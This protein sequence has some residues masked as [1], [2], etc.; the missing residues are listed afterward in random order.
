MNAKLL[1][2]FIFLFFFSAV[3]AQ[4]FPIVEKEEINK[5]IEFANSTSIKRLIVGNI[6]GS[7][8]VVGSD[9]K[10]ILLTGTRINRARNNDKLDDAKTMIKLNIEQE[11]NN[12]AVLVDSPWNSRNGNG[13]Y[14][15]FESYGYEVE[16]QFKLEVPQN[17]KLFLKTVN[18]GDIAVENFSGEYQVENV[19]GSID[20]KNISGFGL[21]STVNGDISVSYSKNPTDECGY[22]TVNGEISTEFLSDLSADVKL[23]TFNGEMFTDFEFV[24]VPQKMADL[25]SGKKKKKFFKKDEF[26]QIKIGEGGPLMRYETL[27]GDIKIHKK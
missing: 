22:R 15:G 26:N 27:N 23:K 9:R 24:S 2:G 14:E 13:N 8:S 10:N 5:T 1:S 6:N 25:S 17:I 19:N 3:S 21:A 12:I 4:K 20:M 16:F 18:N 7:I 11:E